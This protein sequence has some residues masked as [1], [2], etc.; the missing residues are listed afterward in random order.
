MP[1]K[2]SAEAA[3][4]TATVTTMKLYQARAINVAGTNE[5]AHEC[6]AENMSMAYDTIEST[7]D[8]GAEIVTI[9]YDRMIDVAVGE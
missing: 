1:R 6:V 4:L 3:T 2:K 5:T 9:Q 8:D 7:L